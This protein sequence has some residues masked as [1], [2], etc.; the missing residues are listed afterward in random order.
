MLRC[1]VLLS[2]LSLPQP[3]YPSTVITTHLNADFDALASAMAASKLY[4]ASVIVLPGSMERELRNFLKRPDVPD[5]PIKRLREIQ[6]D[7]IEILVIVDTSALNRTGAFMSIITGKKPPEIHLFD[8]HT[9]DSSNSIK[10]DQY[11]HATTGAN[12]TLMT[13]LLREKN[14]PID[15][16]EATL[17]A[18][19]VYEDTGSFTFNSTT[20][21]DMRQTAW[22]LE[23]GADMKLISE[24]IGHRFTPEHIALLNDLLHTAATYTFGKSR[25]T[26]AKTSSPG[27]VEDF[28][29]LAHELMDMKVIPAV[30]TMA[31]MGGQ[32]LIVARSRDSAIDTGVILKELGG[33]GHQSAASANLKG[34]TLQEAEERLVATLNRI[35]GKELQCGQIMTSPAITVLETSPIYEVHDL[36]TKYT[37]SEMPVVSDDGKIQGL[38]SR[39]IVEKAIFHGIASQP[40]SE[41][42]NRDFYH[43]GPEEG[44]ERIKEI[45]IDCR[46][47]FVPVVLNNSVLGV[48]TRTDLLEVMEQDP[49]R[50]PESLLP[51]RAQKKNFSYLMSQKLPAKTLDFLENAGKI[52]A[53]LEFSVYTAG[54]FVRDL[55]LGEKNLDVDLVVEG[56]GILFAK[57][58]AKAYNGRLRI[59][60]KFQTAVV[61]MPDSEK[62]DVA[63]ARRE[64]YQYPAAMPT[65]TISSIK[66][67]LFRRDFTINTMAINL[68]PSLFGELVD[69]FGGQRDIKD[70]VIR[71]LHSLSFVEDP[72]RLF[73]AVRFE[74]RF[75]FKIGRH[76]LNLMKNS[77]NLNM[78]ERLDGKRLF[79]ELRL[80]LEERDPVPALERLKELGLS[81]TI[82]PELFDYNSIKLLRKVHEILGWYNLLYRKPTPKRWLI[83]VM[84]MVWPLDEKGFKKIIN[85]LS[86]QQKQASFIK[87]NIQRGH[88]LK[89]KF[90]SNTKLTDSAIYK[91][92]SGIPVEALLFYMACSGKG[93]IKRAISRFIT[94][95]QDIKPELKGKDLKEMGYKPS[96]L[97]QKML[98]SLL[99]ARL[100]KKIK[101][102]EEEIEFIWENFKDN[103]RL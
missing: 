58:L 48:I 76:T 9:P 42:M 23:Q 32:V 18:L 56:D 103:N 94:E 73:R 72:T 64:Y 26:I 98:N 17:L 67:D 62:I 49:S 3:T 60:K 27:Y 45:I 31:L 47:R 11:T 85:R 71:V 80:I 4:P 14:V 88:H 82:H 8:H 39:G 77:I 68:Q 28:A 44:L 81:E 19:G 87:K 69:F 66:L 84:A 101:T 41:Y 36:F 59:H 43:I 65:V 29:T 5:I 102:R 50:R 34:A 20:P 51:A 74:K 38:I 10:A 7:S 52:A 99:D 25:V 30:F 96:P 86:L 15:P 90:N 12:T 22:L 16:S 37:V 89:T 97:F 1:S 35:L 13:R 53:D 91:N 75:S 24:V 55:I 21:E 93:V 92:L 40:V 33:G 57:E 46:Q 61:I 6:L 78:L 95:L 70:K 83:Y 100:D 2:I 79:T 63:T 54:G